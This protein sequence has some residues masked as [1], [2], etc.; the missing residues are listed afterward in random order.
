MGADTKIAW[1][2]FSWNPWQGCT[3]VS[4]G[5]KYCYMF[6]DKI[7]FGQ[8]PNVVVRSAPATFDKPLKTREGRLI[9]TCSWSDFFHPDADPWRPDAWDI[10]R[11]TPHHR[12]L[13]LTK[14]PQRFKE[15]DVLPPLWYG[16]TFEERAVERSGYDHVGIGVSVE[17]QEYVRRVHQSTRAKMN[18]ISAEPLI[19]PVNL[20][21]DDLAGVEFTQFYDWLIIGGESGNETG[22]YRYRECRLEW[23]EDLVE[24]ARM[25]G[26]A[27]FVK[28]LG[29]HLA[30][31]LGLKH[32]AGA[33]PSEWPAHL[34]I[35]EFPEGFMPRKTSENVI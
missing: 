14:R 21:A 13:L 29:T 16:E 28:Q 8:D 20:F 5:C 24:Q 27:V 11:R 32:R 3:K 25:V 18:F 2:E 35:Q 15:A 33:D 30:K 31:R 7:K 10:I 22:M 1:C 4:P 26:K 6:R 23:I 9:F 19:G 12:Y 34:Q 17:E